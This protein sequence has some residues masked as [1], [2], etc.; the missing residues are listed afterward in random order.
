LKGGLPSTTSKGPAGAL[1]DAALE[2][3]GIDRSAAYVTNTIKHFKWEPRGQRRI[4]QKPPFTPARKKTVNAG[5]QIVN[6]RSRSAP[7]TANRG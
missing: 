2:E 7:S 6:T 4:H 3:A 5:S 1:L